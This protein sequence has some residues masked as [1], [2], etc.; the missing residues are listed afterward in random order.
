MDIPILYLNIF[1]P[2]SCSI[3]RAIEEKLTQLTRVAFVAER[4]DRRN[5]HK[6]NNSKAC[7]LSRA[8][9][10]ENRFSVAFSAHVEFV[11]A[12]DRGID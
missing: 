2:K 1:I 8:H 11:V 9:T 10:V 3:D 7:V 6:F 12:Y 5:V 4:V